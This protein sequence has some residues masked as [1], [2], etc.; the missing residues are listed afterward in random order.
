MGVTT[1]QHGVLHEWQAVA[2]RSIM[3]NCMVNF[4]GFYKV[5]A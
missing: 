3:E 2:R 5:M 1:V 4:A